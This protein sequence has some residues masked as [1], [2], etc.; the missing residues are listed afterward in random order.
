[1]KWLPKEFA[2]GTWFTA[3][4]L[5]F[6]VQDSQEYGSVNASAV[7][8]ERKPEFGSN[9]RIR[10]KVTNREIKEGGKLKKEGK[11]DIKKN[12]IIEWL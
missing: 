4:L 2:A 8:G 7:W 11:L 5:Q 9:R 12:N 10:K 6:Y 1:M 3:D